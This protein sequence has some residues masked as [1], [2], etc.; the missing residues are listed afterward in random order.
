M[1]PLTLQLTDTMR[2]NLPSTLKLFATTEE[3]CGCSIKKKGSLKRGKG[4]FTEFSYKFPKL[5]ESKRKNG[6]ALL[7]IST[8]CASTMLC[9]PTK[10]LPFLYLGSE[11]DAQSEDILKTCRVKYV[12]NASQTAA[13]TPYCS[14]GHYLRIP[15]QDN[16]NE[17]IVTWFQT[18]FDFIDKVKE[19]DDHV[20]LH[21]V[22]GVSRSATIAIAYV[23]KHLSLSLDNAYR[24]VKEKRPTISPNLNFMGQLLQYEQELLKETQ[25]ICTP[26]SELKLEGLKSPS[27]FRNNTYV[28]TENKRLNLN[29]CNAFPSPDSDGTT[30]SSTS[31]DFMPS[32]GSDDIPSPSRSEF[33]NTSEE[34]CRSKPFTLDI[35][36]T[37]K[38]TCKSKGFTLQLN[39]ERR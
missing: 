23:M 1:S 35:N 9:P 27:E 2:P 29:S 25:L 24:Y 14:L 3:G 30:P 32:P 28:F 37:K 19:S 10:V 8:P 38:D 33:V 15:I 31:T 21:C 34:S 26:L 12:L 5:C 7:S 13:D 11:K 39:S 4:G 16:S 36:F 6:C 18:A 22:G 17:N 20:L